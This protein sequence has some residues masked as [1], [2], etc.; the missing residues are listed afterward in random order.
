MLPSAP[1]FSPS[2]S[3]SVDGG[4]PCGGAS[5]QE[6][7]VAN[8]GPSMVVVT[9]VTVLA[10]MVGSLISYFI[11]TGDVFQPIFASWFGEH[12]LFADRRVVIVF[13]A[14]V[15]I[16][17]LSLKKNI[18]DLRWSSTVSVVMLSYLAIA[19]VAI[20]VS[21][22]ISAGFPEH[23]NYFEGGYHTFIAL[24]VLVFAFHC[25][26]QVMPIFAELADNS[27]GFFYE[28]LNEPL[29]G[30]EDKSNE[31]QLCQR[32]SSRV[33]RMDHCIMISMTVCLVS[34]CLV[35]E[36]GYLLYPDVQSDLLISF[37]SS[38]LYLNIARVGM[39]AVSIACFPVC[40]YPCRTILEDGVRY[41]LRDRISEGFSPTLHILLTLFLCGSALVTSL[42]TSDLG[43]VF[44]IVGS[45][46]GVLVI[47][48]IPGFILLKNKLGQV[49]VVNHA[50]TEVPFL[51][52]E[53]GCTK[54]LKTYLRLGCGVLLLCFG[55][56]IF[57]VTAYVTIFG[58]G[59]S[60][61]FLI[62]RSH[63]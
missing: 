55:C 58:K 25:H 7:V 39:A 44:S 59:D 52:E 10:F 45:T 9:C 4:K 49:D 15:V 23:I 27:N 24:D 46:G 8:F 1:A 21:H 42:I 6:L 2:L 22:L 18:R 50:D 36:F 48:I 26:I 14:M 38:N 12:S 51:Q 33:K 32:K 57:F 62:W 43:A 54:A 29:L 3:H 30:D 11:I 47:F 34:Y 35:G 53:S 28:R 61:L 5:F 19:L 56:L 40:H 16:L 41:V 31:E 17:P 37:G 13:F 63:M 20:S 60:K